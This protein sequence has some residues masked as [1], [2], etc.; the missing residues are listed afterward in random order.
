MRRA[1]WR[2][3]SIRLRGA[4]CLAIALL[5]SA[6]GSS[7]PTPDRFTVSPFG[8]HRG[9]AYSSWKAGE[10]ASPE[11][12]AT[13]TEVVHPLGVNWL[14]VV[15]TCYQDTVTATGID[16]ASDGTATDADLAHVIR[17]AH[18]LGMRV[19][20]TPHIDPRTYPAQWRGDIDFG[21][22]AVAW[23]VW[24]ANYTTFIARYA[25]LADTAGA[26]AFV[27]GTELQG[28]TRHETEWRTIVRA[29]RERYRATITYA[30][31]HG[32]ENRVQ[33]WDAVDVIGVD[34]YY[35]LTQRNDPT[36]AEL[37][38]AW[39]PIVSRLGDLA[40]KWNRPVLL[41]EVGYQSLDGTNQ[42][43]WN[44]REG[45]LDLYEQALCYQAVFDEFVGQAWFLGFFWWDIKP[46]RRQGGQF[47]GDYTPIGKP[48]ENVLRGNYMRPP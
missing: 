44:V 43:P 48:A 40:R 7:P 28:T 23:R 46:Q 2:R 24:F 8:V 18:R 47:D 4:A 31:N 41:T 26:E 22:D 38:M 30:A 33:W 12:D 11:S 36:L 17:T 14:S 27:V 19:M 42:T 9:V 37:R 3:I 25:S 20:L 32:E 10:Y 16:C 5:A 39:K 6:C 15:V 1:V 34:G 29:V 13:L 21:N 35:P 45:S